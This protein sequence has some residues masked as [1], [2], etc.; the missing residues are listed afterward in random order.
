MK[1]G[2]AYITLLLFVLLVLFSARTLEAQSNRKIYEKIS[3]PELQSIMKSQG[4]TVDFF[5]EKEVLAWYFDEEISL[6]STDKPYTINF[7]TYKKNVNTTANDVNEWNRQFK[8]SKTFIDTDKDVSLELDLDLSGGITQER[9]VDFL[10]T[11]EVS[12][13]EWNKRVIKQ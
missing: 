1:S 2:K 7:Y 5:E 9:I 4:Y 12:F 3:L 13:K 8:Y 11:C 6:L 10:F